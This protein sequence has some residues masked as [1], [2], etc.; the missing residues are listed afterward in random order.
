V[1]AR[2]VEI[3]PP[4]KWK[5]L[6]HCHQRYTSSRWRGGPSGHWTR[7]R[8]YGASRPSMWRLS[9]SSR[10]FVHATRL[11]HVKGSPSCDYTQLN[12]NLL[13]RVQNV[14]TGYLT[15]SSY[16]VSRWLPILQQCLSLPCVRLPPF[17]A[18]FLLYFSDKYN[19]W[20]A[21]QM[22]QM[23]WIYIYIYRPEVFFLTSIDLRFVMPWSNYFSTIEE[24]NHNP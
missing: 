23:Y 6:Q 3:E 7:L 21:F 9:G 10:M 14:V 24:D 8:L 16:R 22:I 4:R 5:P 2:L 19:L 1:W 13:C 12:W 15:F 18:I 20:S 17:P 11:K